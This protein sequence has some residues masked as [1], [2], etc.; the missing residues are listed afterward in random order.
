MK[1]KICGIT[2]YEDAQYAIQAGTWM[3]GF[4][5]YPKS[6]RYIQPSYALEIISKIKTHILTAGIFVHESP[7]FVME[8]MDALQ[9]DFAQVYTDIAVPQVYKKR[10]IFASQA[11]VASELPPAHILSAYG[12]ILLDAYKSTDGLMGG[13]GRLAQWDL[14]RKL[15]LNYRL[16]LAGGLNVANVKAAIAEVKP[17]A[18]DAASGVE[19][20]PGIKDK[21]LIREFMRACKFDN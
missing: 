2:Q 13:T 15:A 3:L 5:F 8:T 14:A 6:P 20:E 17:F 7:F 10:F 1:T 19:I 16:I 9:L 21:R 4:N 11:R 12:F 18:V